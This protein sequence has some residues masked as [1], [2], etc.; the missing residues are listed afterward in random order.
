MENMTN[1]DVV[2]PG[3]KVLCTIVTNL[4]TVLQHIQM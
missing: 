1:P 4:H 2:S 3:T